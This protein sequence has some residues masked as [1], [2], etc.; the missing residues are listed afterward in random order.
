MAGSL[1][2]PRPGP[3][4]PATKAILIESYLET[5]FPSL[6]EPFEAASRNTLAKIETAVIQKINEG[7][8]ENYMARAAHGFPD[9]TSA[10]VNY[11]VPNPN[12]GMER[13]KVCY[14]ALLT[15]PGG[16]L[17]VSDEDLVVALN[18]E[19]QTANGKS[20]SIR[21]DYGQLY[22]LRS[23]ALTAE[24]FLEVAK[25]WQDEGCNLSDL[26]HWLSTC[27]G[28]Q[29][30]DVMYFRYVGTASIP[31]TS[32][33]MFS[34]DVS[35]RCAGFL[36]QFSDFLQR[37]NP[38]AYA[39]GRVLL[40]VG[41]SAFYMIA[42]RFKD[43]RKMQIVS[44]LGYESLL[45]EDIG[46]S[47]ST[48]FL[49]DRE[50]SAVFLRQRA[51]FFRDMQ[52]RAR[53]PPQDM[54]NRVEGWRHAIVQFA[55]ENPTST[56]VVQHPLSATYLDAV[57][58]QGL[59]LT[60]NG[61][62]VLAVVGK[63]V[64]RG[65]YLASAKQ[66]FLGIE[67]DDPESAAGELRSVTLARFMQEERHTPFAPWVGCS[68]E[69]SWH[70]SE[71]HKDRG[72]VA[73]ANLFPFLRRGELWACI[74]LLREWIE[75]ISPLVLATLGREPSSAAA[76]HFVHP[77]GLGTR[78]YISTVGLPFIATF[79]N[80]EWTETMDATPAGY[81]VLVIPHLDPDFLK[82]QHDPPTRAAALRVIN[83]T[84]QLTF[85][86]SQHAMQN[87]HHVTHRSQLISGL[88]AHVSVSSSAPEIRDLHDALEG[89]KQTLH[90]LLSDQ[91]ANS[92]APP[93]CARSA[94]MDRERVE[95]RILRAEFAL[96]APGSQARMKQIT[97]MWRRNYP[98]VQ[99]Q[100]ISRSGEQEDSWKQWASS[101]AEGTS[102]MLASIHA[103]TTLAEGIS[104]Q[105]RQ[106]LQQV[107]PP[108]ATD[109]SWMTDAVRRQAALKAKAAQ[110]RANWGPQLLSSENQRALAVARYL[111]PSSDPLLQYTSV[112]EGREVAVWADYKIPV[113]WTDP[114][115]SVNHKIMLSAP[116][117]AVGI[118]DNDS[119]RFLAI[120]PRG[121]GLRN[122]TGTYYASYGS[123]MMHG[124][125]P[126]E[127]FRDHELGVAVQRMWQLERARLE[128]APPLSALPAAPLSIAPVP[129]NA[130][131]LIYS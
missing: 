76:A 78:D 66:P 124:I 113:Y 31:R 39:R 115:T 69:N 23:W 105:I 68:I 127:G 16:H 44:F 3:P 58:E 94:E 70:S 101:C 131:T 45:N 114:R 53:P 75:A 126:Q 67:I 36:V 98:D 64:T 42:E 81:E 86:A 11:L 50:Y 51:T 61:N 116:A 125:P 25:A 18:L 12:D 7:T 46:R 112:M 41:A 54:I 33:E 57:L 24:E 122:E 119:R 63:G 59:S 130:L 121:I 10:D 55:N 34:D 123:P 85:A 74:G 32:Q 117:A 87:P 2:F 17:W 111:R 5:Q 89:A 4:R 99:L 21:E 65:E 82:V 48:L 19:E 79:A 97:A 90:T 9:V 84:W 14:W 30:T 43:A 56:G 40:L 88:H 22:Y 38:V 95:E 80:P 28:R 35:E 129:N 20:Q 60:V 83:A 109:D 26:R 103:A 128:P 13:R 120:L 15:A 37:L 77:D 104:D 108:S 107:A 72:F 1:Q 6:H 92:P 29:P 73:F 93:S 47:H 102:F 110:L 100:L 71:R 8:R 49:W 96:G 91:R 106:V 118:D 52:Q 27:V 62:T